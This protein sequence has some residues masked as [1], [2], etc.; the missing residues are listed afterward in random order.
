ML[1]YDVSL[2]NIV[3]LVVTIPT[4]QRLSKTEFVGESYGVSPLGVFF[5][6]EIEKEKKGPAWLAWPGPGRDEAGSFGQPPGPPR[7]G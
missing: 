6:Q 3:L 2:H 7:A 5:R 4:S 1:D